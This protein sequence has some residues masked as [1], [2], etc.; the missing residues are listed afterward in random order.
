M[1]RDV[2]GCTFM[3]KKELSGASISAADVKKLLTGKAIGPKQ[4]TW[5]N[6]KTGAASVYLDGHDLKFKF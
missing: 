3:I 2:K 4:F 6:G 5:K 1:N